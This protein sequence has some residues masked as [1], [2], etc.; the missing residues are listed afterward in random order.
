MSKLIAK[1]IH[2]RQVIPSKESQI[3][4]L[5]KYVFCCLYCTLNLDRWVS[6]TLF[7]LV[8]SPEPLAHGELL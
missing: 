2:R 7:I 6:H 4:M 8:S 3:Y 5:L 1:V